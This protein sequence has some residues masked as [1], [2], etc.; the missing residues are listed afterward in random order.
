MYRY[1]FKRIFDFLMAL[2]G[3]IILFPIILLLI[4][5]IKIQQ[6]GDIFF[7]QDRP[8]L[9]GKV[10]KA[11]KFKTM[12]DK[13]DAQGNLLPDSDRITKIG[14]MIRATSLDELPQ[15]FNILK[16]DMSIVGPRPLLIS[17]LPLYSDFQKRRHEVKPGLTG[18]AQVNGRNAIS[19]GKKFELDV[20]YIENLSFLLDLRIILL[21]IRKVIKK[22][23]VSKEGFSTTQPF[24]GNN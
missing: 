5:L 11:L 1:F 4:L 17:Y 23:G 7:I 14:S 21:T 3:I 2:T 16:G 12:T 9:N 24:N 19:W 15:I 13:K 18:W 10:F 22:E 20:W 8:G 6:G